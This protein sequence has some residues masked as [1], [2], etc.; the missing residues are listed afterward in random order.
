MP[1]VAKIND[2]GYEYEGFKLKMQVKNAV[3]DVDIN[4]AFLRAVEF[5]KWFNENVK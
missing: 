1:V 3:A 2:G 5:I 4:L